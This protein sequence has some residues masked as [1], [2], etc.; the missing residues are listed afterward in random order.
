MESAVYCVYGKDA[1]RAM[2]RVRGSMGG[3]ILDG[4]VGVGELA[5]GNRLQQSFF[6]N[7]RY[8]RDEQVSKALESGCEGYVMIGRFP[9]CALA[10]QLPYQQVDVNVHPNKLEV[11]FQNPESLYR[12]VEELTRATLRSVTVEQALAGTRS[13]P[14]THLSGEF[15]VLELDHRATAREETSAQP[16]AFGNQSQPSVTTGE[17]DETDAAGYTQSG[18]HHH[19]EYFPASAIGEP[20][21]HNQMLAESVGETEPI[22]PQ[23]QNSF[24]KEERLDPATQ[25]AHTP[26]LRESLRMDADRREPFEKCR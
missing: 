26:V 22:Q 7:G 1:L 25:G 16:L 18:G 8:F 15:Q 11:R 9:I 12:A 23:P 5:R 2:R 14:E 17:S 20:Q 4:Y 21:T 3:V 24:L 10:M 13:E 6:I 19:T